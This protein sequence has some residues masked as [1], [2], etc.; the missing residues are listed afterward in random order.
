MFGICHRFEVFS[1]FKCTY[2]I[3]IT[4]MS[5]WDLKISRMRRLQMALDYLKF[6]E[7]EQ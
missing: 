4:S 5:G 6:D 3:I 1:K 7:I 2:E